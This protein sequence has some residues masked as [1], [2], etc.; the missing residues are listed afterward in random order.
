MCMHITIIKETEAMK[1][2]E[3]GGWVHGKHWEGG[4]ERAK[5]YN[6]ILISKTICKLHMQVHNAFLKDLVFTLIL[7]FGSYL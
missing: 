4:K 1:L 6:Y 7:P 3:S 2:S 5:W